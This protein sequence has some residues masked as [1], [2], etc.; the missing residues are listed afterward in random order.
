MFF[1]FSTY[2]F[3][4]F[5][6]WYFTWFIYF[7]VTFFR[8]IYLYFFTYD[9]LIKYDFFHIWSFFSS[10]R[11]YA[12][13]FLMIIFSMCITVFFPTSDFFLF[14]MLF[15][16]VMI[17]MLFFMIG[18]FLTWFYSH[19]LHKSFIFTCDFL[20]LLFFVYYFI[21]SNPPPTHIIHFSHVIFSDDLLI[22]HMDGMWFY[23]SH[24]WIHLQCHGHF[25]P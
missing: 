23:F 9:F 2:Q 12:C 22:L 7:H 11:C 8:F 3:M 17:T 5:S 6:M 21:T 16:P 20:T 15:F 1:F 13:D 19:V 18:F 10:F 24:H 4:C 25:K 14:A